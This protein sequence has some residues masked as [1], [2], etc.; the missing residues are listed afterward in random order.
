MKQEK[1]ILEPK[2]QKGEDGYKVFSIRIKDDTVQKLEYYS[3]ELS[4]SRNELVNILLDYGL[5]NIEIKRWLD[6]K[7]GNWF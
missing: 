1:L 6:K 4:Y 2:I 3:K 7:T 5:E